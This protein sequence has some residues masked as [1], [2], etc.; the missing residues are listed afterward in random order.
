M[1]SSSH[2]N[3]TSRAS[4]V[5]QN[6]DCS[7]VMVLQ[8]DEPLLL[9]DHI[10]NMIKSIKKYPDKNAWNAT[11]SIN[12]EEELN[13]HSFVKCAVANNGQII[14]CFRKTP[15]Y[16]DLT[17]QQTFVRKILGVIAYRK[18]FLLKLN[19]LRNRGA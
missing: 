7:H 15:Y 5:I 16:S 6:Y 10:D 9:P 17:I 18:D 11:G 2:K 4:E 3:G 14:H 13:L 8:G 1:T 19:Q 12:S